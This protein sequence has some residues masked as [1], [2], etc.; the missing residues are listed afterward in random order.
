MTMT[1][2]RYARKRLDLTTGDVVRG[3]RWCL[4][5]MP[6]VR[7]ARLIADAWQPAQAVLPCLSVRSG[8]DLLLASVD[9]PV[10][11]EVIMSA[12]TIPQLALLVREHGF[13]PVA[14]DL[15]LATG[16]VD[17][18]TVEAA[19]TPRTRALVIAQ[20]FG[21]RADLSRLTAIAR[22]HDL[23]LVED[24]AQC[25][26]ATDRGAGGADVSMF[27]FGLIKT[28]TCVG[29]AVLLVTD[30]ALRSRMVDRQREFPVQ[31][32]TA[33]ASKLA[34]AAL[35][36]L[37]T[38]PG[39]YRVATRI[40]QRLTGDFD[41][42]VRAASRGYVDGDLL[43]RIRHRPSR[44]LLSMMAWRLTH[45]DAAALQ[46][47]RQAGLLLAAELVPAVATLGGEGARHSYW[48]FPIVSRTPERLIAAGR[49]AGF[50]LTRGSSTLVAID[51]CCRLADAA[52]R[53]VVYLPAYAELPE[54]A[55]ARLAEVVNAVETG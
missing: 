12:V 28:A 18:T 51:P 46:R 47:R 1:G 45:D 25:Y 23:L 19:R 38:R 39:I 6:P 50:D 35:L 16:S 3:L 2:V 17:P 36:D 8:F 48:L 32:T 22:A 15:D 11:S 27:S 55:L 26:D 24:C 40:A 30:G 44:A 41:A 20:L 34:R 14:V 54:G 9:W 13:V 29:G 53:D 49:A 52:M 10:G 4:R 31:Q 5:P 42:V 21:A 33:Y 7:A 43:V 37:C